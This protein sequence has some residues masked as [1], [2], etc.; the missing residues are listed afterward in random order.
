M[1]LS[2][3]IIITDIKD[4]CK[5]YLNRFKAVL[6]GLIAPRCD[7]IRWMFKGV[8]WGLCEVWLGF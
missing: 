7:C 6:E 2:T 4:N 5:H 8:V 1:Y 3:E